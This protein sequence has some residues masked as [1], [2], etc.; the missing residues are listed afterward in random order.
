VLYLVSL[1]NPF[2]HAVEMIR[3]ALYGMFDPVAT[4]VV[5]GSTV[6]FFCWPCTATIRSAA[7]S[8]APPSRPG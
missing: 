4:A 3:Y 1:A 2:T 7:C 8:A 6:L 5:V